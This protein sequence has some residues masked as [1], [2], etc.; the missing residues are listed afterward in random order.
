MMFVDV[1][2]RGGGGVGKTGDGLCETS[3]RV[4]FLPDD[5]AFFALSI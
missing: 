5:N 3:G 2:Y 4:I 1:I